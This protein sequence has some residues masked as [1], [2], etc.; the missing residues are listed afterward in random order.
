MGA[1]RM[2]GYPINSAQSAEVA[3]RA[4]PRRGEHSVEILREA[5]YSPREIA[6]L[7]DGGVL[8]VGTLAQA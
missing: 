2:P 1:L 8:R 7:E 4:A 6:E 5:G 3:H